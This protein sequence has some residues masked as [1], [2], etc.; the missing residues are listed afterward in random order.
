MNPAG[1]YMY[2][3]LP[4]LLSCVWLGGKSFSVVVVVV[5]VVA[6]LGRWGTAVGVSNY[7]EFPLPSPPNEQIVLSFT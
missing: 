6:I 1:M 7:G 5:V 3:K 2:Q 4:F